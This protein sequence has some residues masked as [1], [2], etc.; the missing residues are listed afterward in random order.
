MRHT[1]ITEWAWQMIL[2]VARWLPTRRLVIV[3]DGTSAVLD[4]LGKVNRLPSVSA[5]TR[6]RLDACVSDPVPAPKPGKKGRAAL[7][8][9]AQ[10]TLAQ[11]LPD[12]TTPWQ[13][14]TVAWYG[15]TT[16]ER[17]IATGTA[18]WSHAPVP[19]VAIRWVLIR[20]PQGP[21]EPMALLCT[22]QQAEA[23]RIVAWC[24]LRWTVDVTFHEGR[25]HLD[26]EIQHHWSDLAILRTTP[27]LLGLFSL[28]TVCAQQVVGEQAFPL[29]Q[30][31][32]STKALPTFSET[33]ACV[34]PH[35]WPSPFFS[36]SSS[37]HD[38][39]HL[40]RTLFDRL[41]ETLSCAA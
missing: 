10:P 8:G 6:V 9:N 20:D 2:H 18:L 24:V 28:V 41:V 39:V 37:E 32:W 11:R 4:V 19:P 12:R 16:R 35:L 5:I 34:R 27:A 13:T 29:R 26:V 40:P 14:Q 23:T 36:G 30:A 33:L 25:A 31:A 15:G 38:T 22:D 21:Y 1:P 7:K 17:E 3:A